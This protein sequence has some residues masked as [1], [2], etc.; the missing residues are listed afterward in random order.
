MRLIVIFF[1]YALV[2][3]QGG[4]AMGPPLDQQTKELNN[5]AQAE[6]KSDAFARGLEQ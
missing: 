1:C 6:I 3:F 2:L 5:K 4:C